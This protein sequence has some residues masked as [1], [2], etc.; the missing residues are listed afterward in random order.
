MFGQGWRLGRIAGIEIRVDPSWTVIALLVAYSLFL[1]FTLTYRALSGPAGIALAVGATALFFGSVLAHEMTH[2]LV[3]RRA[4]IPVR[5]ITLFI[6]GGATHANVESRGPRDEFVVTIVGP[7]SSLVLGGLF[8]GASILGRGVLPP[9]VEGAIG[10]LGWV[11]LLLAVFNLLPG[12]PLDGGRV[13]RSVVWEMTHD[14]RRATRTA[15]FAGVTIGYLLLAGGVVVAFGGAFITGVWFAAIGWFLAR[16]ARASY[17]DFEARE[18]MRDVDVAA[19]MERGLVSV[20]ADATVQEAVE[21]YLL[22]R[23]QDLFPV[24]RDGRTVGV[25]TDRLVQAVPREQRS[26]RLV[27]DAMLS[28]EKLDVE[29]SSAQMNVVLDHLERDGTSFALVVDDGHAVGLLTLADVTRWIIRR[30]D[31]RAA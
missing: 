28:L 1:R 20:P 15:T 23:D 21:H 19:V 31:S 4:G 10:Y 25:I 8:W 13:L 17:V 16:M 24:D 14:L 11:N 9:P 30:W 26:T 5:D 18:A 27:R 12:F 7:L 2:A 6:F 3:A 22:G 29:R